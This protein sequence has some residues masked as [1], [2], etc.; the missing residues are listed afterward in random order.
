MLKLKEGTKATKSCTFP[1]TRQNVAVKSAK[2]IVQHRPPQ[3]AYITCTFTCKSLYQTSLTT[4]YC[5]VDGGDFLPI[6]TITV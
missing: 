2:F 1:N 3:P 4:I 5:Q 6:K